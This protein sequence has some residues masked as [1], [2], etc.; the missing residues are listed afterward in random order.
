M[1]EW[2]RSTKTWRTPRKT[3]KAWKNAAACVCFRGKSKFSFNCCL[4]LICWLRSAQDK[5]SCPS[6]QNHHVYGLVGVEAAA[7]QGE[8]RVNRYV[9]DKNAALFGRTTAFSVRLCT[10]GLQEMFHHTVGHLRS[11]KLFSSIRFA[12]LCLRQFQI[13]YGVN[14][15]LGKRHS[16][17]INSSVFFHYLLLLIENRWLL[18]E[19]AL[20][21][22][23]VHQRPLTPFTVL[24]MTC[25]RFVLLSK[26]IFAK[27]NTI[28]KYFHHIVHRFPNVRK[29]QRIVFCHF[30]PRTASKVPAV[31][32]GSASHH[33]REIFGR[34]GELCLAWPQI[35]CSGSKCETPTGG[36]RQ[37]GLCWLK[38][39]RHCLVLPGRGVVLFYRLESSDSFLWLISVQNS[40]FA[41]TRPCGG[42]SHFETA[43]WQKSPASS[44]TPV[45]TVFCCWAA[46]SGNV[47]AP[48]KSPV[49]CQSIVAAV[50]ALKL[51][52]CAHLESHVSNLIIAWR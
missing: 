5:T 17:H 21:D 24:L 31:P 42:L 12:W 44:A 10:R 4:F 16:V 1:R 38:A 39:F 33:F 13:H 40:S 29:Y 41:Q 6:S 28:S 23:S 52:K 51:I 8:K 9:E 26:L 50:E 14:W 48:C 25:C 15:G 20:T 3:S 22:E 11:V 27:G 34:P 36:F 37:G 49:Y 45:S 35:S 30:V 7:F 2:T 43:N 19:L 47:F 32:C 18:F 46:A